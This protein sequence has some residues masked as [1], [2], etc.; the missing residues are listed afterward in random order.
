MME[1]EITPS[2]AVVEVPAAVA[3]AEAQLVDEV[4]ELWL[5]HSQAQTSISK[6]RDEL[7]L[8]R[9]DLSQRLH[10][11]KAVLSRPGRGG[12]WFSFLQ[13]QKIPRSTAD[14]L[15]RGHDKTISA[16][17]D[18]CTGEQIP[19]TNEVVVHRYARALWPKL[20]R[21][22]KTRE[23][24]QVFTAELLRLSERSFAEDASLGS[25]PTK[26]ADLPSYLRN[27]NLP[28]SEVLDNAAR[29]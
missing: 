16:D 19:E 3:S 20:R 28:V 11:L 17:R 2:I 29:I 13:A 23:S 14:R 25:S 24:V 8:V 18:S 6:T 4:G 1:T 27:L 9:A 26:R 7:K 15:V 10:A 5:I 22:L 21:I 12:A